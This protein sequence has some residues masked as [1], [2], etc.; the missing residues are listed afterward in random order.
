MA[1]CVVGK[2]SNLQNWFHLMPKIH[3]SFLH[4]LLHLTSTSHLKLLHFDFIMLLDDRRQHFMYCHRLAGRLSCQK[5]ATL[6]C[7]QETVLNFWYCVA[8][9]VLNLD[10]QNDSL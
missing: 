6:L 8:T 1:A 3:C 7:V 4:V 10:K 9:E 2:S 5:S